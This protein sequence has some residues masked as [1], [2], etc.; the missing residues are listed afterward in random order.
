M[1]DSKSSNHEALLRGCADGDE[2]A[3]EGLVRVFSPL[4]Y[5]VVRQKALLCLISLPQNDIDEII[6]QTFTNIWR[7]KSLS[8]L[9]SAKSIPAYLTVI[10]QN[11]AID[12]FRNNIRQNNVKKKYSVD[13]KYEKTPRD[14]SLQKEMSSI[15]DDFIAG[16][17]FKERQIIMSE[18]V[19][20][21]KHR[22][23]AYL[24]DIPVNTVSTIVSRLKNLLKEKLR[25][26]GYDA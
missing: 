24:M 11:T 23:I 14:E 3:W 2:K 15:V 1:F 7:R 18:L 10:A 19:Y 17:T 12:F 13:A 26:R 22:E 21:L 9:T 25:E 20:E 8:R 6:H 4:V 5:K 16:L